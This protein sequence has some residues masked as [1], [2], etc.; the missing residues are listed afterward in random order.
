MNGLNMTFF[1]LLYAGDYH[2]DTL[3]HKSFFR[4]IIVTKDI[5]TDTTPPEEHTPFNTMPYAFS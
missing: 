3:T 1:F 4:H 2:M 5:F